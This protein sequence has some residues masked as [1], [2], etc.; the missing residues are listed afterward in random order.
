MTDPVLIVLYVLLSLAAVFLG[1]GLLNL[2]CEA[3]T[4]RRLKRQLR[5]AEDRIGVSH[6]L[7]H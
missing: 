4:M 6:W 5:A 3:I 2:V 7:V 1:F